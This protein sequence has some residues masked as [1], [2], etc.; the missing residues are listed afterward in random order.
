MAEETNQY[1]ELRR[2]KAAELRSRGINPYANG[3]AADATTAG[4]AARFGETDAAGLEAVQ[5]TFSLAGRI[6]AIRSFGKAAMPASEEEPPMLQSFDVR[7]KHVF[8][9][10]NVKKQTMYII[11]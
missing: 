1:V 5:E 2:Q 9:P 11:Y 4:I 6:M 8:S 10:L 3:I 7:S